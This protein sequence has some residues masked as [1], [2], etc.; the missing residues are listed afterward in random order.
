MSF[1][2]KNYNWFFQCFF[3]TIE[4]F[5]FSDCTRNHRRFQLFGLFSSVSL[6]HYH[7]EVVEFSCFSISIKSSIDSRDEIPIG[8][9]QRRSSTW[10]MSSEVSDDHI[11]NYYFSD[12]VRSKHENIERKT[13]LNY[14]VKVNLH[15]KWIEPDQFRFTSRFRTRK[16][17]WYSNILCI[18]FT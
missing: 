11:N 8:L 18:V 16:S 17:Q 4:N 14:P 2:F 7:C 15:L 10:L 3:V 1:I 6:I 12:L 5:L 13:S 9:T